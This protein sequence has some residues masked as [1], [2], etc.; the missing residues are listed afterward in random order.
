VRSCPVSAQRAVWQRFQAR[1][2]VPSF[3]GWAL[4]L[5]SK[6]LCGELGCLSCLIQY[7]GRWS[8]SRTRSK[9]LECYCLH[10]QQTTTPHYK[11][12]FIKQNDFFYDTHLQARAPVPRW[13]RG[14]RHIAVLTCQATG[15]EHAAAAELASE[16]RYG[17]ALHLHSL[18]EDTAIISFGLLTG[19]SNI[20]HEPQGHELYGEMVPGV[21]ESPVRSPHNTS[22]HPPYHQ[23]QCPWS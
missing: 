16:R 2:V 14:C 7:V 21:E 11:V 8:C 15:E 4:H 9:I 17:L 6:Y 23:R 18:L 22:S 12:F 19:I 13:S 3:E 5:A 1:S 10:R 20:A